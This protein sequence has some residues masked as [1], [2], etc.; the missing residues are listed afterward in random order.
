MAQTVTDGP[1]AGGC[2]ERATLPAGAGNALQLNLPAWVRKC[3]IAFYDS[4]ASPADGKW[5]R[6]KTQVDGAAMSA[7]ASRISAGAAYEV[8]VATGGRQLEGCTLYLS[9]TASG[10]ALLDME[11]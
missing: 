3:T 9:G 5:L 7:H 6:G 2:S 11:L 4:A 8:T 1:L 10:Y